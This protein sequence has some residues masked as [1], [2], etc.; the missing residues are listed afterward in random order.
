VRTDG[1]DHTDESTDDGGETDHDTTVADPDIADP[2]HVDHLGKYDED[3]EHHGGP[4]AGGWDRRDWRGGESTW[5]MLG[6][7]L[8]AATLSLLLGIVP[9]I[10]VFLRIVETVVGGLPGVLA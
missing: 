5:F 7:I 2:E 3:H 8:T 10:A 9:R 1:G 4:P 6:P